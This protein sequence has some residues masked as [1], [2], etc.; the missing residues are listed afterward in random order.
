MTTPSSQKMT[1]LLVA[2]RNGDQ[3]AVDCQNLVIPDFIDFLRTV[4]ARCQ[5]V[6]I[7]IFVIWFLQINA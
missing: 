5:N 1:Q 3:E 6:G 4:A 2:W 7:F